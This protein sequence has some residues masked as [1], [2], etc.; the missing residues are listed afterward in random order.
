MNIFDRLRDAVRYSDLPRKL[1][2]RFLKTG[3]LNSN[4]AYNSWYRRRIEKIISE[5][6]EFPRTVA[7]ETSSYCNAR[8]VMCAY[9][10]MKRKKGFMPWE[11][12][13]RAVDECV[14]HKVETLYLSGF[15]EPLTD[16]NLAAKVAYAHSRGLR[17]SIVTNASLLERRRARELV[18]AGLDEVNISIDG[19]TPEVYNPIRIG[20][21]FGQVS[22]NIHALVES[23]RNHLPRVTLEMVVIGANKSEI[24]LARS[25]WG[26]VVDSLV[27]R[28]PQDW[29][30]GVELS[31]GVYTP[32]RGRSRKGWPPCIYPFTQLSVYW[33]GTVPVCCLD[34]DAEGKVGTLGSQ[35]LAQIWQGRILNEYRRFHL[36]RKG[37]LPLPCNR[38]F[39][40][41]VWW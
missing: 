25:R 14:E 5:R 3:L 31:G 7:L 11:L 8:C 13:A 20:L 4:P 26:G 27:V 29:M 33:D 22:E 16:K 15:G 38:C 36:A 24:P 23:R 1:S 18:D 40:F 19:F 12:F 32:H 39:Y 2:Y 10:A 17:T 35:S 9:P 34:Y 30:G 21:D 37:D 41:S 28:Q 6:S